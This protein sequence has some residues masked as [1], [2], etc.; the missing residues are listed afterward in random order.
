MEPDIITASRGRYCSPPKDR[1][2]LLQWVE[3]PTNLDR[4]AEAFRR[5]C[6]GYV[7]TNRLFAVQSGPLY[8][9]WPAVIS[10][11]ET[12]IK[13]IGLATGHI[14]MLGR[15]RTAEVVDRLEAAVKELRDIKEALSLSYTL[16]SLPMDARPI[17]DLEQGVE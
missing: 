2:K 10:M 5:V 17:S 15:S 6:S 3:D 12:G 11:L 7:S 8:Y 16:G 13:D 1:E 4:V 9:D 14:E